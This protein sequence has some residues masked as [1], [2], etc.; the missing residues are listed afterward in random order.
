MTTS[1]VLNVLPLTWCARGGFIDVIHMILL[2]IRS[3]ASNAQS[4]SSAKIQ[5]DF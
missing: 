1:M 3:E 5:I 2:V 4:E